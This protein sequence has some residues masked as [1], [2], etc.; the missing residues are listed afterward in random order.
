MYIIVRTKSQLGWL[1]LPHSPTLPP[2]VT[3][4]RLRGW[5]HPPQFTKIKNRVFSSI[6]RQTD[7]LQNMKEPIKTTNALRF[8]K[9]T[10]FYHHNHF[11]LP[12]NT[13]VHH[14]NKKNGRL[15]LPECM[16]SNACCLL[17]LFLSVRFVYMDHVSELKLM[18]ACMYVC[19]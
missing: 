16:I 13:T 17:L 3:A 2:P 6:L 15:P 1:N 12:T 5:V 8:I 4:K 10:L 14:L 18:Y 9:Y 11:Y 19:I 7:F